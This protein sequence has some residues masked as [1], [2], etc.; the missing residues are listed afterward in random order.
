M[1]R[2]Q[3]KIEVADDPDKAQAKAIVRFS[4]EASKI[5]TLIRKH[6]ATVGDAIE[7]IEK[8]EKR[9]EENLKIFEVE[10]KLETAS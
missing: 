4:K 9:F 6:R 7:K 3:E 8:A 1:L 2:E 5:I 10:P